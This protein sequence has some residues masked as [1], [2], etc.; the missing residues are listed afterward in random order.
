MSG[1]R[2]RW[3][4]FGRI[5]LSD[6][7]LAGPRRPYIK[8]VRLRRVREAYTRVSETTIKETRVTKWRKYLCEMRLGEGRKRDTGERGWV[9]VK[10]RESINRDRVT[11]NR[12]Y[13]R[14]RHDDKCLV[15]RF[16]LPTCVEGH[17]RPDDVAIIK[18]QDSYIVIPRD[19]NFIS[20]PH[21]CTNV[22]KYF[23]FLS[24]PVS[25]LKRTETNVLFY[26]ECT[27]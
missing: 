20:F 17:L 10:K 8:L 11:G 16:Q 21:E 12:W 13:H 9:R 2:S 7:S 19:D 18:T 4:G 24:E 26:I 1:P 22:V 27:F 3:I 15:H 5:D 23:F 25:L 6:R 14:H